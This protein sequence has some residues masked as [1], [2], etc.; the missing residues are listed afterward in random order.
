QRAAGRRMNR[1]REVV[2]G[3]A[4]DAEIDGRDQLVRRALDPDEFEKL[5]A[6]TEQSLRKFCKLSGRRRA[7]LY[8]LAAATGL[9]K[10]EIASLRP[11]SFRLDSSP[12]HIQVEASCTKNKKIATQPVPLS[13]VPL[14]RDYL[15]GL[16]ADEPVWPIG[17]GLTN[18]M[19]KKDLI[20]AGIPVAV[21]GQTFDFHSL[22][23]QYATRLAK[24]GVGLAAA[25]KLLRHCTPTLTANVYTHLGLTD[26]AKEVEKLG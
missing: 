14:L 3:T 21:A 4:V 1:G 6:T 7:M 5:V 13:L 2:V 20:E 9:R 25:Q 16:P 22:R 8:R 10:K 15:K 23:G 17:K 11:W 26:L 19:V 12:P 18:L 24:A